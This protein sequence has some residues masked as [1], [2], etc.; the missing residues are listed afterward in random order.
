MSSLYELTQQ[1]A[2]LQQMLEDGEI[3]E[4]A[5]KDTL[6]A[7]GTGE[8]VENICKVIRNLEADAEAYKK[9]KDRLASKQKVAE[10]SVKRLK[11]LLVNYLLTTNAKSLKQGNFKVSLG[12]SERIKI[13]YEDMI[14]EEYLTPQ[15]P[16][17]DSAGIKKAIKEGEEIAGATI[18]TGYHV[19][20]R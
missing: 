6:D 5:F 2:V 20:I 8:K 14:P 12:T 18:E 10:N 19:T 13:L 4:Q 3:D 16:K 11:E 15:P 1:A 17:I 7:M 9:E